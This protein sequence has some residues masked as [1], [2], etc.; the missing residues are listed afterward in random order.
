MRKLVT[1][2]AA[3]AAVLTFTVGPANA[4]QY[5]QPDGNGHPWVGLVSFHDAKGVPLW[6]CTGSLIDADTFLTAAH[7]TEAPAAKA[8]IWFDAGPIN[9]TNGW[10][11]GTPCKGLPVTRAL[12]TRRERRSRIRIGTVG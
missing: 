7:C 4:V 3:L 11:S 5:G 9:I 8:V 12:V 1:L 2:A 10:T 6:R